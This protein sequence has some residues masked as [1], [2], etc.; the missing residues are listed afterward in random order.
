[1]HLEHVGKVLST[2]ERDH[3]VANQ[4]KCEFGQTQIKYLGH[5]ISHRGVEMNDEKIRAVVE[6]ERPRLVKSLRGF[7]GLS[8]YYQ[9]IINDYGRI[10][11]PLTELLK[12]GDSPGMR[13]RR[14]HG[15]L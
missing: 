15:K 6:W 11:K 14:R 4:R 7:L 12:K 9:R 3:W 8:G 13:G 2:L 10:A 5:V 1:M